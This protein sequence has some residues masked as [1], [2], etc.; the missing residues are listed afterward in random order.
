M[1]GWGSPPSTPTGGRP[2]VT[3]EASIGRPK[4]TWSKVEEEAMRKLNIKE[5]VVEDRQQ[6]RPLI[7]YPTPGVEN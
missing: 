3:G 4:K 7:S 1:E 6:W 2:H 5:D